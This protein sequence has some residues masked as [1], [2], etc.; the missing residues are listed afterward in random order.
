MGDE[1]STPRTAARLDAA[2]NRAAGDSADT[3]Q[4]LRN[5]L[6]ES[7]DRRLVVIGGASG[8]GIVVSGAGLAVLF[9]LMG[10]DAVAATSGGLIVL[11]G[12]GIGVLCGGCFSMKLVPRMK[13]EGLLGDDEFADDAWAGDPLQAWDTPLGVDENKRYNL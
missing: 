5:D 1:G 7:T 12:I 4:H 10:A 2:A 3:E 13:K 9:F 8:A 6:D 11:G